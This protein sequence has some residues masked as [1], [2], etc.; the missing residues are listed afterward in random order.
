MLPDFPEAKD[1]ARRLFL[2]AVRSQIPQHEPLLGDIKHSR[3]H[4]GES[5][6]LTRQDESTDEIEF[7]V[8]GAE[9]EVTRE[10]MRR[11]TIDQLLE[12][13]SSVADQLA[14]QQSQLMFRRLSQA[15]EQVGNSISAAELGIKQGF[16]EMQR[17]LE[18]DFDPET[19]EPKNLVLVLHPSQTEQFL[20]QA[21]EWDK[22]PEFVAEMEKIRQQQIEAWRAREDRRKLVD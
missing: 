8:T 13:V 22:D 6:R 5:A 21:A 9:F 1:H 20:A 11:V 14:A 3:I 10:Q 18:V 2:R 12:H 7:E 16:L 4:E 17:R 15:V 19:L